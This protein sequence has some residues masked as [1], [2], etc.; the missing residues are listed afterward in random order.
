[1]DFIDFL[2]S[3]ELEDIE[4][5]FEEYRALGPL[6][7]I[8]LP[9]LESFLPFLPLFLFVIANANSFGLWFGSLFSWI[10]TV[11]GSVI[12]FLLVR[13]FGQERFFRFLSRHEKVRRMMNW[14]E[15]HGFGP[16][17]IMLCFPFTPSAAI[18]VVAGLS[19]INVWQFMLAA[20]CGKAV[21]I[22][23]MSYIGHDLRALVE[24]PFRTV[25]VIAVVIILWFIGKRIESRLNVSLAER[26]KKTG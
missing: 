21:M 4:A 7:G 19:R 1:M 8:V 12:V 20:I 18:N 24:Q 25:V 9:M 2:L 16:L 23:M 10:G 17:F 5:L 13:K 6:A 26:N 22:F 3:I 14:V 11:T 15:R